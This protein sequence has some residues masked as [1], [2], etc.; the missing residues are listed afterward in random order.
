MDNEKDLLTVE[1]T[2]DEAEKAYK[3]EDWAEEADVESAKN[4]WDG[5]KM[6]TQEEYERQLSQDYEKEQTAK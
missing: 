3:P 6:V 5:E 1:L 4:V 2:Q